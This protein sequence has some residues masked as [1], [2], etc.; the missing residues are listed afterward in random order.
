[1]AAMGRFGPRL[2]VTGV[3]IFPVIIIAPHAPLV[4]IH[5]RKFYFRCWLFRRE[6]LKYGLLGTIATFSQ[7]SRELGRLT[8]SRHGW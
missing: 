1:M 3:R 8:H 7:G 4:F 2:E 6:K 5:I